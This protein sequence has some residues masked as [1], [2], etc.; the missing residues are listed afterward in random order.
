M[1]EA[2]T[3][4]TRE[5]STRYAWNDQLVSNTPWLMTAERHEKRF[6]AFRDPTNAD[7]GGCCGLGFVVITNDD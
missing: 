7:M 1:T 5:S 4:F 2:S 3:P 6:V